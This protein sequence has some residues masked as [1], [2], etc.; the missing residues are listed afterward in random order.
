MEIQP[1]ADDF[2]SIAKAGTRIPVFMELTADCETPISAYAKLAQEKPAF[3]FESIVG[4]ENI[5]RYSFL[6]VAPKKIFRIYQNTTT[7]E[8]KD[9]GWNPFPPLMNPST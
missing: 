1:T 2:K 4:G 3:L 7:V 8:N 9:G 5:S 6:G